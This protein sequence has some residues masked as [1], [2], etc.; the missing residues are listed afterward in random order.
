MT[1]TKHERRDAHARRLAEHDA[2]ELQ[3]RSDPA[4]VLIRHVALAPG[5]DIEARLRQLMAEPPGLS[6]MIDSGADIGALRPT[7]PPITTD[8]AAELEAHLATLATVE[9]IDLLG[10]VRALKSRA[11]DGQ[12]IG[13][14]AEAQRVLRA[15]GNDAL[16]DALGDAFRP[17]IG[18]AFTLEVR[19]ALLEKLHA[20]HMET[21]EKRGATPAPARDFVLWLAEQPG[22]T[23]PWASPR[24]LVAAARLHAKLSNDERGPKG[25]K[26]R[27][28]SPVGKCGLSS[29]IE[30]AG[31]MGLLRTR[32][33]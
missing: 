3:R 26:G 9:Q 32:G 11:D 10:R 16:A 23:T 4:H 31:Q 22:V 2:A 33:S 19:C 6:K 12:A 17:L 7:T 21:E 25:W 15:T 24:A 5:E 18:G 20:Q 8:D 30:Q 29:A 1:A 14:L 28:S 27:V 13:P